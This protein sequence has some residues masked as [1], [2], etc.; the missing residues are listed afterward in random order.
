MWE[1][2]YAILTDPMQQ[3]RIILRTVISDQVGGNVGHTLHSAKQKDFEKIP[4]QSAHL[5]DVLLKIIPHL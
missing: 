2:I 4:A 5:L 1:I 3:W